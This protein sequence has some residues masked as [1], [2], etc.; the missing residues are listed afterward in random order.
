M[1]S[2]IFDITDNYHQGN[3]YSVLANESVREIKV[4]LRSMVVSFVSEQGEY[5]A[6]SDEVEQALG[7][8]HQTASARL[9]EAKALGMVE[10]SGRKRKTRSGRNAAVLV[11]V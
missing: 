4:R 7:M 1:Q 11:A 10:D 6:T 2:S 9:T 8:P 3:E 5:G